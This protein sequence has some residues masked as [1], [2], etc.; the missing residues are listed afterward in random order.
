MDNH[1][2]YREH[3]EGTS[4]RELSRRTGLAMATIRS[5]LKK[6]GYSPRSPR[7]ARILSNKQRDWSQYPTKTTSQNVRALERRKMEIVQEYRTAHG[8]VKCGLNH[9]AALDLHHRDPS[10]KHPKLCSYES[11]SGKGRIG[12]RGWNS[13]SYADIEEELAKCDVLCS[14]CHRILEWEARQK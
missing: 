4:L 7:D 1:T 11:G 5:R 6:A 14:N 2:I 12:G 10:T 3:L 13:L 8:C 9:T